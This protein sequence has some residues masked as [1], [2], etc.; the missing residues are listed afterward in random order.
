MKI[1][2]AI[3]FLFA[4]VVIACSSE[5]DKNIAK[6]TPFSNAVVQ[7]ELLNASRDTLYVE[8]TASKMMP[9]S[10]SESNMLVLH[11]K[12]KYFLNIVVDKP[13]KGQ[14][15]INDQLFNILIVPD[16]TI[17]IGV[18]TK[19]SVKLSFSGS[20]HEINEYYKKKQEK[21][22][23]YDIRSP[24][25]DKLTSRSSYNS[26]K[27]S[28]DSI[29]ETELSFLKNYPSAPELPGW[30]LDL[31]YSEI[32]YAGADFKVS[33]PNFNSKFKLFTDSL[34]SDYYDFLEQIKID[35]ASALLS[36]HYLWFLDSYFLKGMPP[37]YDELSGFARSS[38]VRSY[39][40]KFSKST[41]SGEVKE[42]YHK[43][44]F[45]YLIKYYSD[46]LE[47]D[48]LAKAFDLTDYKEFIELSGKVS[49][50]GMPILNIQKGDTIPDFYATNIADSLVSIRAFNDKIVYIN[51]WATWCG[52]C[53]QNIPNLN[54]MIADYGEDDRIEFINICISSEKDKWIPL[55]SQHKLLGTNLLAEGQWNN[56]LKSY[57]NIKGIPQYVIL[58]KG[59]ILVENFAN[60]APLVKDQLDETLL[61]L[62]K[63][64]K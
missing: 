63:S 5:P 41:L 61:Q 2:R 9:V 47:I 15:A 35:N 23:Y 19:D 7:I 40:L 8:A 12:G 57:F 3:Y 10:R 29:V 32:E 30:F 55:L 60:K 48:S 56:K 36:S 51:I 59:N 24:I 45:S 31:E 13:T 21:F 6:Y 62:V 1:K 42:A 44:H 43:S 46:T 22:G 37:E 38:E 28:T 4:L 49:K 20:Y 64:S 52:P 26:I 54:Q 50:D 14:L 53:I 39:I 18:S 17:Q 34:P 33:A 11:D 27:A 16:D 25:N 58:G